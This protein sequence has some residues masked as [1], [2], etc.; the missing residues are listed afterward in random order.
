MGWLWFLGT[1]VPMIGLVPVGEQAMADRYAYL[2][3][4]GLFIAAVWGIADWARAKQVPVTCLVVLS[5]CVL[6]PLAVVTHTQIGYWKDTKTLWTHALAVTGPNFVAEDSLG[7][8][9]IDEGKLQEAVSHFQTAAAI[10][11]ARC[12]QP[13]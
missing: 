12:V 8:E 11:P 4:I 5:C 6:G 13:P 3:F 7:A 1:M 9:L 10:N 2:P